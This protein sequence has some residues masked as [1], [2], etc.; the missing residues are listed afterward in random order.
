MTESYI[1]KIQKWY[2]NLPG[3]RKC[4]SKRL[5]WKYICVYCYHDKYSEDCISCKNGLIHA[6][7]VHP[8]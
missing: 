8:P 1:I 6:N 2:R 4:G 7:T 5:A 3:C